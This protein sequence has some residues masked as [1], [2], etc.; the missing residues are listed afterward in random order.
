MQVLSEV[1]RSYIIESLTAPIGISHFWSFSGHQLDFKL[2]PL[3]YLEETI[4]PAIK[5]RA[6]NLDIIVPASWHIMAVDRETSV[7]DSLPIAQCATHD[8]NILLFS[9]ADGSPKLVKVAAIDFIKKTSVFHPMIPKGSAMVHPTGPEKKH[10]KL[11]FYGIVIG[12]HDL[13]KW[14]G[15]RT[16]GD[17]FT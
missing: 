5:I 6:Q 7:A 1:N 11:H 9:P 2:E 15:G 10:N 14:I 8:H 13:F 16:I 12:P 4:G 17:I 3:N